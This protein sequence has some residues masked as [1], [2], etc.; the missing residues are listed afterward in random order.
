MISQFINY[1]FKFSLFK[2]SKKYTSSRAITPPNA[3]S[4]SLL[5]NISFNLLYFYIHLYTSYKIFIQFD[6]NLKDYSFL[7]GGH[8]S[9]QLS[10]MTYNYN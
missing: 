7:N 1:L 8:E 10:F 6:Q 5:P 9:L 3:F 4:W 2:S